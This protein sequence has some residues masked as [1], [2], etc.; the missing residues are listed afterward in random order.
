MGKKKTV[1]VRKAAWLGRDDVSCVALLQ[2]AHADLRACGG[3]AQLRNGSRQ[4]LAEDLA[5]LCARNACLTLQ[6][7][8]K[9]LCKRGV[10][11]DLLEGLA[12]LL[13]VAL[14][15]LLYTDLLDF[16]GALGIDTIW[17]LSVPLADFEGMGVRSYGMFAC[18]RGLFSEQR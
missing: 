14:L 10:G 1:W 5:D 18:L 11:F 9:L 2:Q 13:A 12:D 16:G 6:R 4:A 7:V 8:R 17:H 15:A 3:L